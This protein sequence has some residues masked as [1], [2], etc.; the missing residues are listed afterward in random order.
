MLLLSHKLSGFFLIVFSTG[1]FD[2]LNSNLVLEDLILDL[3]IHRHELLFEFFDL[4]PHDTHHL[5]R[6]SD[7][8]LLLVDELGLGVELHDL[9]ANL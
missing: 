3:C 1:L 5:F 7:C 9:L 4:V 6:I 2:G 8:F